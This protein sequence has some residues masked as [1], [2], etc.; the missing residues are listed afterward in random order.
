MNKPTKRD[1]N[2]WKIYKENLFNIKKKTEEK[3]IYK[4]KTY[5]LLSENKH[6]FNKVDLKLNKLL[7]SRKIKID[8]YLDLHGDNKF[9]AK[10]KVLE[11]IRNCFH[12]QS[13]NAV[14]IT[15]KGDNNNGVLKTETPKWLQEDDTAKFI[16][17]YSYMPNHSGGEGAIF[18]KIRNITKLY[19]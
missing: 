3:E 19:T 8:A 7:K 6:N 13:R 18:V 12:Q 16:I 15:G 14:I 5:K 4:K 11:F 1:L 9:V 17:Q 2:L 10:K